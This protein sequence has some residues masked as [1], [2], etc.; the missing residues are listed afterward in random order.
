M[1]NKEYLETFFPDGTPVKIYP[2]KEQTEELDVEADEI[3]T[4][5]ALAQ[6]SPVIEHGT[7]NAVYYKDMIVLS[8]QYSNTIVNDI[9]NTYPQIK[10]VITISNKS[11]E[12][13]ITNH[14]NNS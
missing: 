6:T 8:G 10:H 12:R 9:K 7:V 5:L 3:E 4:M 2:V 13:R 1:E 14:D 11:F